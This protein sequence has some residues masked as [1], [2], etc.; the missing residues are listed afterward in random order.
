MSAAAV[1][2]AAF[3]VPRRPGHRG[4]P[5]RVQGPHPEPRPGVDGS[6]VMTGAELAD[7][8]DLIPLYDGIRR[9]PHIADGI[10][11]QC[12]CASAPGYRSLLICFEGGGMATYCEIC[13][14]EGRMVVR[15]H[16]AGRTLDQIRAAVDARF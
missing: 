10:R 15:L 2:L 14:S 8:P 13:Q 6:K 7:T 9:I 3:G 12:G 4:R 11:C 5:A 16:D 1:M